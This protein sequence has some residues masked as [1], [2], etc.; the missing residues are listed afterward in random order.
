MF[1]LLL[2]LTC[3]P[4]LSKGQSTVSFN[5]DLQSKAYTQAIAEY[6]KAVKKI[7]K[8]IID[9]LFIGRYEYLKDIKLPAIIQNTKIYKVTSDKEGDK[10]LK[11][12]KSFHYVNIV[13]PGLAKEPA[14]FIFIRFFVEKSSGLTKW[15]PIHNCTIDLNYNAKTKVFK[16][17]KHSFEYPY[18]NSY[19]KKK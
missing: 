2:F 15:W 14:S 3:F 4:F 6:I 18:S 11:H 5:K 12:R 8:T 9:T 1:R 16:I 19:T 7:D 13:G 17:D 10:I